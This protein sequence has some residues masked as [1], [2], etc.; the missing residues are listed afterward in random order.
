MK[1]T[2]FGNLKLNLVS[3]QEI[4]ESV[5]HSGF[6]PQQQQQQEAFNPFDVTDEQVQSQ[7]GQFQ[8][9]DFREKGLEEFLAD[10]EKECLEQHKFLQGEPMVEPQNTSI[11]SG[12]SDKSI[13]LRNNGLGEETRI[14]RYFQLNSSRSVPFPHCRSCPPLQFLSSFIVPF[15]Y[16]RSSPPLQFL[17]S[18]KVPFLYH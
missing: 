2:S 16:C 15:P 5:F 12:I 13:V 10:A 14:S 7:G 17:S 3:F 11:L 9:C 1:I 4:N 8:E 18:I 6:P